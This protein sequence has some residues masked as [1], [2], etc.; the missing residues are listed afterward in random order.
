M[1][2]FPWKNL[3][4]VVLMDAY[5]NEGIEKQGH[6]FFEVL[7]SVDSLDIS[8]N[9]ILYLPNKL[10]KPMLNLSSLYLSR[11]LLQAIPVQLVDHTK[12]K[13]LDVRNNIITSVSSTIRNWA[14]QIQERHGMSLFLDAFLCNCDN[15]DF[16]RWIKTT[17]VDLDS[18]SYKCQLSNETVTDTLTAYNSLS[19]LFADCKSNIW[20]TFALTLLS[21]CVTISFL[22][23]FYSKRWKIAFSIY[24]VIHRTIE[25]KV[26]KIYQYD[27]YM[28]YEGECD[29]ISRS[30]DCDIK[31]VFNEKL[32]VKIA[33]CKNRGLQFIPQD[34][35]RD[36]NVLD[37]SSNQLKSIENS[38]LINYTHLQELNVKKNQFNH[39]SD[40]SFQ[41]LNNL[42]VLDMS[43][44]LLD[45]AYAY[46]AELFFPIQH[47]TKLD[48]RSNMPQ[49]ENYDKE[50]DYPDHA[51]GVLRELA[52]LESYTF[53]HVI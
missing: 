19:N 25:K 27:V 44:N 48:I 50:F 53:N 39:L 34:L 12:I 13:V 21:T 23:V 30:S 36:I 38:S 20:L 14:D 49:P 33:D 29:E 37:M 47:L 2:R 26:R 40:K 8:R 17:K 6:Q 52:F 46:L 32:A 16:I 3:K 31:Y 51:F 15:L 7:S 28:S 11:N 41:G 43:Y 9:D 10:L 35:P 22:L 5:L 42:A 24:G 18:Q 1:K 4:T 45:L